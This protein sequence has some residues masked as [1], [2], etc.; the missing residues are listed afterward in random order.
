MALN[1]PVLVM[2]VNAT[3]KIVFNFGNFLGTKPTEDGIFVMM[4]FQFIIGN[5]YYQGSN[6]LFLV[7]IF[8]ELAQ[9]NLLNLLSFRFY[10][11]V[12]TILICLENV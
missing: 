11:I 12:T 5:K 10:V 9:V 4:L 8:E 3:E 2:W 1:N 6:I 7:S